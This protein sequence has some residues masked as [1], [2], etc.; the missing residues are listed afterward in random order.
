M[1]VDRLKFEATPRK[2]EVTGLWLAPEAASHALVLSHAAS[3]NIEHASMVAIAEALH[4]VGIATFRYN[5][6][7]MEKGGGGLDGKVTCYE[8]VR[9]AVS[10]ARKMAKGIPL[11]AGGR[12]FGGRMTSMAAAE[13]T[14]DGLVGIVFYAFPLHPAKKPSIDRADHL[15]SV[16]LPM[17][18]LSG[19]RDALA[20]HDLLEPVVAGLP[21][22]TLHTIETAD[23]SFKVLKRSGMTEALAQEQAAAAVNAWANTI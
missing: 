23:H 5:F 9:S 16:G 17:L 4:D 1:N 11:L 22:A 14:I 12:S 2:G 20:E 3:T 6:P 21:N 10:R 19:T 13:S 8:T 7:Y 15:E 18:F